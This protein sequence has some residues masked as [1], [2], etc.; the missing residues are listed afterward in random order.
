M[1]CATV[2]SKRDA[3]PRKTSPISDRVENHGTSQE[4]SQTAMHTWKSVALVIFDTLLLLQQNT[5]CYWNPV[6]TEYLTKKQARRQALQ[7]CPIS[8][9][10][11]TRTTDLR[12]AEVR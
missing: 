12:F 6:F 4:N 11:E 9:H 7:C 10:K 8:C 5:V 1:R 2:I 3:L